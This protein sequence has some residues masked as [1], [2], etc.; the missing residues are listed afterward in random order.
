MNTYQLIE[1]LSQSRYPSIPFNFNLQVASIVSD[2]LYRC[3][4]EIKD[5]NIQG[6]SIE[7]TGEATTDDE[8]TIY[9]PDFKIIEEVT[10][11]LS[12]QDIDIKY[13]SIINI[14]D[15]QNRNHIIIIIHFIEP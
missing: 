8:E 5:V 3:F 12:T 7:I 14:T 15:N 9:L 6:N 1:K 2:R 11:T 10:L 4:S 13:Q